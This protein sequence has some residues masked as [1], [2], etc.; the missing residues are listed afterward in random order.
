[1]RENRERENKERG[2]EKGNRVGENE[3]KLNRVW[4]ELKWIVKYIKSNVGKK[5]KLHDIQIFRYSLNLRW[6]ESM[7]YLLVLNFESQNSIPTV[8]Y[9]TVSMGIISISIFDQPSTP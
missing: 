7:E 8:L 9:Q 6:V 2:S 3:E 5:I 4:G 1:M